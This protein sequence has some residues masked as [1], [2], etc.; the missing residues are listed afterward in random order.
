MICCLNSQ[1]PPTLSTRFCNEN[2]FSR[3]RF[4]IKLSQ[5]RKKHE[6]YFLLFRESVKIVRWGALG[7]EVTYKSDEH[8]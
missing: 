1:W 4:A 8:P 7:D 6:Q 2:T 3:S 5:L